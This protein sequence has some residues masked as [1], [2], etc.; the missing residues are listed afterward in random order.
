VERLNGE[1]SIL[2]GAKPHVGCGNVVALN[3]AGAPYG[4]SF[5]T[6]P[7]NSPDLNW[8]DLAFFYSLQCD[9]NELKGITCDLPHL[10]DC[11]LQ[12]FE[13]Y[14]SDKLERLDALQYEIYRQIIEHDGSNDFP[15]P[16]SHIRKRQQK[17][18]ECAD[19]SV[20]T[21]LYERMLNTI[22]E[23]EARILQVV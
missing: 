20:P 22:S 4:I 19:R 1:T 8:C 13:E 9:T 14:P 12:A 18:E 6:Q 15:M 21:E 16:H 23:L 3:A 10:R 5:V 7:S 2:D 17:G 11:V